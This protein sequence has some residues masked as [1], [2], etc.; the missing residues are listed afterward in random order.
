MDTD[1]RRREDIDVWLKTERAPQREA[2]SITEGLE[3]W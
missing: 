1:F 3:T 2:R